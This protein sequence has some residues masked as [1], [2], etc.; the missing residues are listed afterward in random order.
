M[1]RWIET[2]LTGSIIRVVLTLLVGIFIGLK[3]PEGVKL[4]CTLADTLDVA[5][6]L[7]EDQTTNGN[8]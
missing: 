4:T 1:N 7:C 8:M 3:F 2:A 6:T 5:I